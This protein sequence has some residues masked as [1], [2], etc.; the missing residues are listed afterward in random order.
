[1]VEITSVAGLCITAAL[2]CKVIEKYNREQAAVTSIAVL[3]V[4]MIVIIP[5][6][7]PIMS[8]VNSIFENSGIDS[9]NVSIIFKA[10][11]ISCI[12]QLASDICRDCG[13]NAIASSSE[14]FGKITLII[15]A[16]PLF[17]ELIQM[18]NSLL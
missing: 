10:L 13:E 6:T 3:S 18:V 16:L 8:S 4:L 11:G 14:T 12:T 9:E 7:L 2:M 17:S 5:M 15:M 1:M